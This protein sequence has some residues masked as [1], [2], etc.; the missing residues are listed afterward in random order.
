MKKLLM[1]PAVVGGLLI[2]APQAFAHCDS[3][4]GPVAG[5]AME[6]LES[7]NVN[8]VL[9]YAPA[10]AAPELR[11]VFEQAVKVRA[12]GGD[13]KELADRHFIET[14]VRL[15][16]AGEGAPYTGLKPADT[17]FGPAI[18]AAERAIETGDVDPVEALLVEEVRHA[19]KERFAHIAATRATGEALAANDLPAARER[20]TA[21]LGFIGYV[22]GVHRAVHGEETHAE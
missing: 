18:P 1:V 21:E 6:A 3:L 22:E 8:R 2:G 5:A 14:A 20:V 4:G 11:D 9:A 10:S 16:R 12:G 7:G 15:H 19:V 17:D 13:A